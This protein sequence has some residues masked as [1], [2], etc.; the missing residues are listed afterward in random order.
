M[1]SP[2]SVNMKA[3]NATMTEAATL[4][5][6]VVLNGRPGSDVLPNHLATQGFYLLRAR[7]Q[8]R[9]ITATLAN[10]K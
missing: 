5:P 9:E 2:I 1:L 10:R 4:Q 3:I 7:I 8:L 6:L